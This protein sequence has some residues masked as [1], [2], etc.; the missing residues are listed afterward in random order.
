MTVAKPTYWVSMGQWMGLTI[1]QHRRLDAYCR[2]MGMELG[3]DLMG[4][5]TNDIARQDEFQKDHDEDVADM[6]LGGKRYRER[7]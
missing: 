7:R 4:D 6:S 3:I 1:E 5:H 2:E